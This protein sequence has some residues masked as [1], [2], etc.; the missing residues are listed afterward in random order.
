MATNI[1]EFKCDLTKEQT[2]FVYE[3]LSE[4][5]P[6][7]Y[8]TAVEKYKIF[9][10]SFLIRNRNEDD[11]FG[12]INSGYWERVYSFFKEMCAKH[13]IEHRVI[14]RAALNVTTFDTDK[15]GELHDDHRFPHKVFI[16]YL[17][18]FS[19][20]ALYI[21]DR[22]TKKLIEIKAEKYKVVIFDGQMHAQGFCGNGERRVAL[23]FTFN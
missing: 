20:G 4:A 22:D 6:L 5:F 8:G 15:M 10:H 1:I 21:Q 19:N 2:E 7:Y 13:G 9:S 11:N 18:D 14:Y 23:V 17:N 16:M 3:M 12:V